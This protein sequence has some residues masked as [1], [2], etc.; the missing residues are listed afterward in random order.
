MVTDDIS[1]TSGRLL[2]ID[3][4]TKT[5]LIDTALDLCVSPKRKLGIKT[6]ATPYEIFAAFIRIFR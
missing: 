4:V 5:E 2:V 6:A 3:R 1:P